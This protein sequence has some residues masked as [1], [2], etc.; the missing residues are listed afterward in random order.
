MDGKIWY[1]DMDTL[2][3]GLSHG[4]PFLINIG[5]AH[6]KI[7]LTATQ[8]QKGKTNFNIQ[9]KNSHP[10]HDFIRSMFFLLIIYLLH[11]TEY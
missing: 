3:Y 10:L 5:L 6:L 1:Y 2:L 4:S 9:A 8:M 7:L 11:F